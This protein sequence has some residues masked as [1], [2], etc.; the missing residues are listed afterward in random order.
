MTLF[1]L[2]ELFLPPALTHADEHG[3]DQFHHTAFIP[4]M[5][6]DL[7]PPPVLFKSAF[8]Q[9]RRAHILA[10]A[11]G[12]L[13]MIETGFRIVRQAPARF[14]KGLLILGQQRLLAALAFLKGWGIPHVGH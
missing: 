13:Q 2:V 5:R 11:C 3:K 6:N 12:H 8:R 10:M 4:Q 7:R 9:V 1:E 14:R